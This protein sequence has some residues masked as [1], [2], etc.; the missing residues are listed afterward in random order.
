MAEST[1]AVTFDDLR[2]EVGFYLGF[3]RSPAN[4]TSE[5]AATVESVIKSGLRQFYF[6]PPVNGYVHQWHF[7]RPQTS[8]TTTANTSTVDCPDDF[9]ALDGPMTYASNVA[10]Y[11]VRHVSEDIIRRKQQQS[12]RTGK[13]E[14]VAVRPRANDNFPASEGQRWEFVFWPTPDAEYTLY[15][16]YRIMPD[17]L[18]TSNQYPYGGAMHGETI[19]QSCLAVA[20]HRLD[21]KRGHHWERFM[22]RL[23]ASIRLDIE[24]EAADALGYNADGG[25]VTVYR[26]F[27]V[28]TSFG[29]S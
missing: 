21:D 10:T 7:L 8:L 17:A 24:Q 23:A 19:L 18:D 3:G 15:Y 2:Q 25:S 14:M 9:A 12:N 28:E 11:I 5:Q 26:K 16:R 13:P 1:L 27:S 29:G 22:E 20:E 6:P 4:W